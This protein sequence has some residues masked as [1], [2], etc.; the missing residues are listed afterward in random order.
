MCLQSG[1]CNTSALPVSTDADGNDKLDDDT[2]K[3]REKQIDNENE[4]SSKKTLDNVKNC[5]NQIRDEGSIATP[6]TVR[7][8]KW[9]INI[10]GIA[11]ARA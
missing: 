11:H 7:S 9:L 4:Q 8:G 1:K 2:A 3:K 6:K 10:K 5:S